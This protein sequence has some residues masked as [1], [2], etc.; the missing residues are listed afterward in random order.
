[1]YIIQSLGGVIGGAVLFLLFLLG[2]FL[3][4]RTFFRICM[5]NEALVF[6]GGFRKGSEIV[7]GGR[8]LYIPFF[9]R[10]SRLPLTLF[11]VP[12][13]VRNSYSSG[14]IAMNIDAI[15][16]VKVSSDQAVLRN[17]VERFLDQDI[18][19]IR[20]VAKETLEG[21]LRGVIANLTPEQVN[22]DRLKFADGLT[23][24]SESDLRKLGLHLDT[25]K[26]LHVSDD[27]GYLD[28]TGRKAIANVVREAEIAE[29]DANRTAE[30]VEAENRGRGEVTAA[31][32]DT[33]IIGL[34]NELRKM[35]ADFESAVN[36]EE[37]RTT[38]AAREARAVAEQRLQ[39]IRAQLEEIRLVADRVLPAEA[40]RQ[41]AE[42]QARGEAAIIRERG[43]AASES[44]ATLGA[45]WQEAGG[46]AT[47][48][49]LIEDIEKLLRS[50]A[51]G[52]QK[53]QVE[54]L[55]VIDGG[56]GRT[57]PNYLASYPQ[58]LD[59]V[60]AAVERTTGMDVTAALRGRPDN[61]AE[62]QENS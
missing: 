5:P 23:S 13:Q 22:E 16:N 34:R 42:Y 43:R 35:K 59:S 30:L 52:V 7:T 18:N 57:L 8:K 3:L 39:E 11:E 58:M 19:T 55:S 21:H 17:A 50:A 14:G 51:V 26:I 24:E 36:A 41:A 46:A 9:M 45:A 15:A 49:A 10:V 37:E 53:L 27:V 54:S 2:F 48:I 12:I 44:L 29:S 60:F 31:E 28:A 6:S 62:A 40:E 20:R 33:K 4:V 1:M 32:M 56:D 47:Q 25:L 38:A 61:A